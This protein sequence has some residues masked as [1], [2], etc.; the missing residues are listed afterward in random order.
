MRFEGG[1]NPDDYGDMRSFDVIPEG[2][3]KAFITEEKEKKTKAG[4]GFYLELI[5]EIQE[6]EHK[7]RRIWTRLNISNP[8]PAAV[9]I[10]ERELKAITTACVGRTIQ[11][12]SELLEKPLAIVVGI[13][14]ERWDGQDREK[15]IITGYYSKSEYQASVKHSPGHQARNPD[16]PHEKQR[17]DRDPPI[18]HST[19]IYDPEH[20]ITMFEKD[21]GSMH[22]ETKGW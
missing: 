5:F 9:D 2:T 21:R 20:P 17:I 3:Y 19:A 16:Q 18:Q 1:F 8:N 4:D 15:N 13:K 10:A 14:R 11:D 22:E 6:G 12:S 7:G